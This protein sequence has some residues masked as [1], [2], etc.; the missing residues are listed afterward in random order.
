MAR[1]LR[2]TTCQFRAPFVINSAKFHAAF[3]RLDPTPLPEAVQRTVAWCRSREPE[4]RPGQRLTHYSVVCGG[5]A[6]ASGLSSQACPS[7]LCYL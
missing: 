7:E 4:V 5:L 3:G 1:E 2:E 6:G